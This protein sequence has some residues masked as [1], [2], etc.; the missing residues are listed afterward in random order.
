MS[1]RGGWYPRVSWCGKRKTHGLPDRKKCGFSTTQLLV[2]IAYLKF[3]GE[4]PTFRWFSP[5][6]Q[7]KISIFA[8]NTLLY[9]HFR[10]NS[11]GGNYWKPCFSQP[12]IDRYWQYSQTCPLKTKTVGWLVDDR[13]GLLCS[14]LIY[15]WMI[16]PKQG[17]PLTNHWMKAFWLD[18]WHCPNGDA[19]P[20]FLLVYRH[21]CWSIGSYWEHERFFA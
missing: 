14:I 15:I 18:A 8:N 19:S 4:S 3:P 1:G 10:T 9:R 21:F 12:N 20:P 6:Y 13:W 7:F 5:L 17:T 16:I 2:Y 11:S